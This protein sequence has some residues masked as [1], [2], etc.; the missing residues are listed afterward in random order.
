MRILA[1]VVAG[2]VAMGLATSAHAGSRPR[3]LATSLPFATPDWVA[4]HA[5][6]E[7]ADGVIST[8]SFGE[9]QTGTGWRLGHT[10]IGVYGAAGVSVES[11]REVSPSPTSDPDLP[12]AAPVIGQTRAAYA[13][14]GLRIAFG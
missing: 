12:D 3:N 1:L 10:Q 6:A 11:V 2:I 8:G 14:L 13:M 7:T 5:G 9:I 4:V